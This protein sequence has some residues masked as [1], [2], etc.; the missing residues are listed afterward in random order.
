MPYTPDE[1][2]SKAG[3]RKRIRK[4]KEGRADFI[5]DIIDL[6]MPAD[7]YEKRDEMAKQLAIDRANRKK[8]EAQVLENFRQKRL[9]RIQEQML[10]QKQIETI[11]D[12]VEY[13]LIN[14]C[15]P[16]AFRY[17]NEIR[18][19]DNELCKK[20]TYALFPPKVMKDLHKYVTRVYS[21]GPPKEKITLLTIQ[22][23]ERA[24][25]GKKPKIEIERDGE[26]TE[27]GEKFRGR[28]VA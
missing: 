25:K 23:Y 19:K 12:M 16:D 15:E 6:D 11:N 27:I 28:K 5:E 26:R 20:I 14:I 13:L 18:K 10:S 1:D 8:A 17:L 21:H 24:F 22:K 3:K 9:K 4:A 7:F 2:V